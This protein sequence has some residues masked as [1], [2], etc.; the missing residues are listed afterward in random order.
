[1]IT[2][3]DYLHTLLDLELSA[4]Y[5]ELA[6]ARGQQ[7]LKD[8]PAHRAA[9]DDVL[10]RMDTLLDMRLAARPPLG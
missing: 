6:H 10:A 5:G 3:P 2:T 9:V 4:T 1:M 7:R 8:T